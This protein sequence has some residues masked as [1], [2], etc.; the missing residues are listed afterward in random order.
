MSKFHQISARRVKTL[1]NEYIV[2]VETLSNR[3]NGTPCYNVTI[4]IIGIYC[5]DFY[6]NAI[7][8]KGYYKN[9]FAICEVAISMYESEK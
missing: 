2:T 7:K 3:K 4:A 6:A 9:D 8:I 5:N 1:K